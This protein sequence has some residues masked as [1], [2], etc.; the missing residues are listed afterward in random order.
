MSVMLYKDLLRHPL[1]WLCLLSLF[2]ALLP[3]RVAAF[4]TQLL[5]SQRYARIELFL[6]QQQQTNNVFQE[7]NTIACI[8]EQWVDE[9]KLQLNATSVALKRTT[10]LFLAGQQIEA[11]KLL[12]DLMYALDQQ[13]IVVNKIDREPYPVAGVTSALIS[14]SALITS[15]YS[16]GHEMEYHT[17]ARRWWNKMQTSH[18][19]GF[20]SSQ[21]PHL[22]VMLLR[23]GLLLNW[24]E[25]EL[26]SSIC[27]RLAQGDALVR[28][29][30]REIIRTVLSFSRQE[31]ELAEE[32]IVLL[33][34]YLRRMRKYNIRTEL[35]RTTLVR[36]LKAIQRIL[37]VASRFHMSD[38]LLTKE[39]RVTYYTLAAE[40]FKATENTEDSPTSPSEAYL[41]WQVSRDLSLNPEDTLRTTIMNRLEANSKYLIQKATLRELALLSDVF[42]LSTKFKTAQIV[43]RIGQV[44]ENDP[45]VISGEVHPWIISSV[46]RYAVLAIP[47]TT[48]TCDRNA[49]EKHGLLE[50]FRRPSV[51][52]PDPSNELLVKPF[53]KVLLDLLQRPDFLTRT[54][55]DQV[56]NFLWFSHSVRL[57]N[58]DAIFALGNRV[59]DP[60]VSANCSP[61]IACRLLGSCTSIFFFSDDWDDS[62]NVNER[63]DLLSR[64]FSALG[65]HLLTVNMSVLDISTALYAYGKAS[66]VQDMGVFDHLT[67]QMV[68]RI[69]KNDETVTLRQIAQ[70]LWACGKMCGK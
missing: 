34:T 21:K 4:Q 60:E 25:D 33:K 45:A 29:N 68:D 42:L 64:I 63:Q 1:A 9:R 24:N 11:S 52:D 44:L 48:K 54:S 38:N 8:E 28:I 66:F 19:E 13:I 62:G 36:I 59:L 69:R 65:E 67:T 55:A 18:S 31:R 58:K 43:R 41:L 51:T 2:I 47:Q 3:L 7:C 49:P 20:V 53:K 35:D 6:Q 37:K 14:L 27:Q 40:F 57:Y 70:S 61:K 56:A 39:L 5:P 17:F 30:D 22:L 50:L 10:Q 46:L 12:P 26:Y 15:P 32:E 23:M 16:E